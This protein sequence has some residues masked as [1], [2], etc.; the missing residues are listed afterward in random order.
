MAKDSQGEGGVRVVSSEE[1][2]LG[3]GVGEESG[4]D[5]GWDD[6]LGEESDAPVEEDY[7]TFAT[8]DYVISY[9]QEF[10]VTIM[11][12]LTEGDQVRVANISFTDGTHVASLDPRSGESVSLLVD[13]LYAEVLLNKEGD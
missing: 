2:V 5:M 11:D 8:P 13:S 12:V 1:A 4:R 10:I 6:G 3:V 7:L 9:L